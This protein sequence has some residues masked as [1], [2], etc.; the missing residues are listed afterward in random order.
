MERKLEV[1]DN[2]TGVSWLKGK[3]DAWDAV[4]FT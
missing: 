4:D 1:V 2:P 3:S